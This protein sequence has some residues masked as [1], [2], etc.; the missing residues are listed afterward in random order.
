[1]RSVMA[2]DWIQKK[3]VTDYDY[4]TATKHIPRN[5]AY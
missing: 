3:N 2:I 4:E 5:V 1:M